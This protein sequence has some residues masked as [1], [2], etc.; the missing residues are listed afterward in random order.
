MI[1]V[2]LRDLSIN[3]EP[4]PLSDNIP[5]PLYLCLIP[6]QMADIILQYGINVNE[7]TFQDTDN[8]DHYPLQLIPCNRNSGYRSKKRVPPCLLENFVNEI[9][10]RLNRQ[11]ATNDGNWDKSEKFFQKIDFKFRVAPRN[12]ITLSSLQPVV[13]GA[14]NADFVSK[15]RAEEAEVPNK[16]KKRYNGQKKQFESVNEPSNRDKLLDEIGEDGSSQAG[17]LEWKFQM[18]T[19]RLMSPQLFSAFNQAAAQI[20]ARFDTHRDVKYYLEDPTKKS[21][22]A[23]LIEYELLEG[24]TNLRVYTDARAQQRATEKKIFAIYSLRNKR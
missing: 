23:N 2:R 20:D 5:V 6:S 21:H 18:N 16:N 13:R 1:S 14:G 24:E 7:S 3:D 22:L 4:S 9:A 17:M 12:S 11:I 15:E 8:V 10:G 19:H